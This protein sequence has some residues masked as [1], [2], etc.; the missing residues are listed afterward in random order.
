MFVMVF[1]AVITVFTAAVG[2][3]AAFNLKLANQRGETDRA[4]YA[5]QTGTQLILSLMREPPPDL[6]YDGDGN[7]GTWLGEDGSMQLTSPSTKS[8]A[9]AHV[10][11]NIQG[12]DH[13][14]TTAPDGTVIPPDHFYIISVGVVNGVYDASGNLQSG[15]SYEANT[16][17]ASLNPSYPIIPFA[18]FGFTGVDI[19]GSVSHFD[20]RVPTTPTAGSW[21]P[22]DGGA[23]TGKPMDC[24]YPEASV[25][26]NATSDTDVV[27]G[28]NAKIDGSILFGSATTDIVRQQESDDISVA[29]GG[30][31]G[32][33]P[34]HPPA[35]SPHGYAY[36]QT[37]KLANVSPVGD[38]PILNGV[39]DV[40]QEDKSTNIAP[41]V[42]PADYA[43]TY[44]SGYSGNFNLQEGQVYYVDGNMYVGASQSININDTNGDGK[45]DDVVIIVKDNIDFNGANIGANGL[46]PPRHIKIYSQNGTT[47]NM[48]NSNAF[49]M[50]AGPHLAADIDGTSTLWGAVIADTVKLHTGG[51]VNFDVALR[52]PIAVAD[53][54]GF[55]LTGANIASGANVA[56]GSM[57]PWGTSAAPAP[58]PATAAPAPATAAP[59]P[60]PAPATTTG[61]CCG[62]GCGSM[63]QVNK[64]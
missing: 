5:A 9:I 27:I 48:V 19:D 7:I 50:V 14:T 24:P 2:A 62:C 33:G 11:H 25:A 4:Y 15:V 55:Y 30:S 8:E 22:S 58:A 16:M 32:N 1:A 46:T 59:A 23:G 44:S 40:L 10:Y 49:C 42:D 38:D 60:A 21:G 31:A 54:Y 39:I 61:G 64:V 37:K 47:F 29:H 52:D 3:Q 6:D 63:L 45:I 34:P 51:A 18:I 17:G 26:V 12:F 41:D 36:G 20:S 57:G 28:P 35:H 43:S 56:T 13:A 53:I